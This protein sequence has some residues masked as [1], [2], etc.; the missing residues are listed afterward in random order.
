MIPSKQTRDTLGERG[1]RNCGCDSSSISHHKITISSIP[2]TITVFCKILYS[3]AQMSKT[4]DSAPVLIILKTTVGGK[5][6]SLRKQPTFAWRRYH[7]FPRQMPS[8]KR[9]QK[10]HT[11][12][13]SLPDLGSASDWSCRVEN[14][15]Q[16]IRGMTGHQYGISA[17]ISQTSFGGE[18]SGRFVK[19]RLFS[20]ARNYEAFKILKCLGVNCECAF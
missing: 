12:D 8:E 14:L 13:A 4:Q 16:P 10:F 5:S 6:C 3:G 2:L 20:Q 17:L 15:I 7:W 19:C 9:A 11:D 18:T 1:A